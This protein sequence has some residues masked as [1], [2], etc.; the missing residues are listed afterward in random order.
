MPQKENYF[1]SSAQTK[2]CPKKFNKE[3]TTFM[4]HFHIQLAIQSLNF[5]VM[6][7]TFKDKNKR[8]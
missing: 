7:R 1:S 3:D 8:P 6:S 2:L 5:V 4:C